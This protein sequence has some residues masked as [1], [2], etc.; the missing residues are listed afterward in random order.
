MIAPDSNWATGAPPPL[1]SVSTNRRH[2]VV[3]RDLEKVRREL[4]AASD[5]HRLDRVG[6][7]EFLKQ[8]RHLLAVGRGP[9]IEIEHRR[10]GGLISP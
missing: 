1:G 2:A 7:A 9:V 4:I 5:V 6:N 3:G 8:D 10:T